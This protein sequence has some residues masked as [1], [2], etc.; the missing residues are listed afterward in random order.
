LTLL[1]CLLAAQA[2]FF[3]ESSA[4][5]NSSHQC[6]VCKTGTCAMPAPAPSLSAIQL[7]AALLAEAALPIVAAQLSDPSA[8]RAPPLS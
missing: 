2:H 6:Q 3:T 5:Q 8:P 7:S 1:A 4:I